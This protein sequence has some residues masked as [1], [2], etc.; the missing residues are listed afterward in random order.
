LMPNR[1]VGLSC[2]YGHR[3]MTIVHLWLRAPYR[4][5]GIES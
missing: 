3:N 5:A 4:Y 2:V 1:I